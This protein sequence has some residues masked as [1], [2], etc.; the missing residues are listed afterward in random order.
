[1]HLF[2]SFDVSNTGRGFGRGAGF[3]D[4]TAEGESPFDCLFVL[5]GIF[6]TGG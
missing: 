1:M 3:G 2:P 6:K 5:L 4:I